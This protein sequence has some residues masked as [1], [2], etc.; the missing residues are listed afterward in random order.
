M[1]KIKIYLAKWLRNLANALDPEY[2]IND[3]ASDYYLSETT[4][5]VESISVKLEYPNELL[6]NKGFDKL[7]RF[8]M[9]HKI[10][11]TLVSGNFIKISREIGIGKVACTAQI[12]V[13]KPDE[14]ER[15]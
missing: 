7:S 13:I 4:K 6:V 2:R 5:K 3:F 8:D 1:K 10:A 15:I 14:Y 11:E 9:S 12:N